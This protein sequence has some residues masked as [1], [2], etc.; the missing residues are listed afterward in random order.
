MTLALTL[1]VHGVPF[2]CRETQ[3]AGG[4]ADYRST[5]CSV[6]NRV[7]RVDRDAWDSG[8]V[9]EAG[10]VQGGNTTAWAGRSAYEAVGITLAAARPPDG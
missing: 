7:D 9:G 2:L 1:A 10:Q 6:G 4:L 3:E 8:R 5:V